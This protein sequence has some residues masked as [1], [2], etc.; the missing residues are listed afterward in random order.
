LSENVSITPTFTIIVPTFNHAKYLGAALD[1]VLSQSFPDWEAVVVNDGSTDGTAAILGDYASRDSRIRVFHQP[2]SG[3]AAAL[4]R[5]LSE[6]RGFWINWLSSDDMF[7]PNKL[8]VNYDWIRR[9]PGCNFFFSYFSLLR[10]STG[11]VTKND[12]WGPLP[13]PEH[14]V[15]TLFYRNFLSGIT[16]C[17]RREAWEK[18]GQFDAT[19]YYGQDYDQWLRLLRN[20]QAIFIPEW[21]VI[22]R[23][24]AE[25][26]SET[27]PEAC[28]FDTARAAIRFINKTPFPD[29][30]PFADLSDARMA[31]D[32]VRLTLEIACNPSSFL[33]AL[34][35]HPALILRLLEWVT[36]D[37][38]RDE[39]LRET[40]DKRISHCLATMALAEGNGDWEWMWRTLAAVWGNRGSQFVYSPVDPAIL[41]RHELTSREIGR[42]SGASLPLKEYL[43]RFLG[44]TGLET[45]E[46]TVSSIVILSR[47]PAFP[48]DVLGREALHRVLRGH[49]VAVIGRNGSPYEW[50]N[51]AP[52]LTWEGYD[53]D[54]MPWMGRVDLCLVCDD[55]GESVWLEADRWWTPASPEGTDIG[56]A[57]DRAL[58]DLNE[59]P[60]SP[61]TDVVFLERV[62]AGGGAERVVMDTVARLDRKKFHVSILTLFD[63][64]PCNDLRSDVEV[65]CLR[66]VASVGEQCTSV[67]G[68]QCASITVT[69][70]WSFRALKHVFHSVTNK[71]IRTKLRILNRLHHLYHGMQR[72]K[73]FARRCWHASPATIVSKARSVIRC[74]VRQRN[75]VGSSDES[76]TSPSVAPQTSLLTCHDTFLYALAAHWSA[77]YVISEYLKNCAKNVVLITVMEEAAA[78]A[79][80]SQLYF[81][82][83]RHIAWF[84]TLESAYLPEMYPEAGRCQVER[85]VLGNA[86][87]GASRVIFPSL[88]CRADLITSFGVDGTRVGVIPNP[89]NISRVRRLSLTPIPLD[90]GVREPKLFRF[91]CVARFSLEKNHALLIRACRLL[92][93]R[94]V[95]FEVVLVGGGPLENEIKSLIE[96][97]DLAEQFQLL[98]VLD[99]PYPVMASSGALVLTSHFEAFGVVLLEAMACGTPVIT[100]NCPSGPTEVLDGGRY[101]IL[102]PPNNPE[103]LASTM[104]QLVEDEDLRANLIESAYERIRA[105][106]V[107]HVTSQWETLIEKEVRVCPPVTIK[108]EA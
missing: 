95:K 18:V 40:L 21:L 91:V 28:Y 97:Y 4:N 14:Q 20:N 42:S 105:F 31:L 55:Q 35:P 82:E 46:R 30:V 2:N 62:L 50:N 51:G 47:D 76:S 63:G 16:I 79:W 69:P 77:S 11:E 38:I 98:G 5:G 73:V 103:A 108:A 13:K 104:Q 57:L 86:A 71:K 45:A 37:G 17:I 99:N 34:G 107:R 25:Q 64:P 48:L 89:I 87:Q 22:N 83:L 101:G 67:E 41:G 39:Y 26:C 32:A 6:A 106:D 59:P 90:D 75:P 102:V 93:D 33:Y 78:A 70:H 7:E 81:P 54:I 74:S 61:V 53:R 72:A 58:Q 12:L 9:F 27:F 80:I 24:H 94:F 10:E 100:T 8:R 49:Q 23:N 29:I 15:L 52:I 66:P 92:K 68:E 60:S 96:N 56:R 84:H 36:S 3:V 88:G 44:Q 19:L 43:T 85:W 65:H 1:S